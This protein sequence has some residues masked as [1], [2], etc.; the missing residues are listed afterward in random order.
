VNKVDQFESVF[1][2]AVRRGFEY[3]CIAVSKILV[4]S[5]LED[6]V[7]ARFLRRLQSFLPVLA[8]EKPRWD[9]I[10]TARFSTAEAL[11]NEVTRRAPDL[12][13]CYRNL[14]TTAWK[15]PYSLGVHLDVLL[16]CCAAPVLVVPHPKA[17]YAATH[18]L[19]ATRT[20]MA[21]VD[22]L[23]DD[24]RLVNTAVRMVATDGSLFL[25]HIEDGVVFDRY[26]DAI[27]KI[28]SIDTEQAR[29]EIAKRLLE[30][31]RNYFDSCQA[32]IAQARPDITQQRVLAFGRHLD[33]YRSSID[34]HRIDLLVMNG[35]DD[36]QMAM[37]SQAWPL[38][39]ELRQIPL[40][41]L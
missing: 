26:L 22:A 36:S 37:H 12:V 8:A 19:S 7:A 3:Q 5:D 28:A 14:A 20:V 18:A 31:S 25:T 34:E 33:A 38:A 35:K 11:L 21:V 40:L 13:C 41:I 2:A 39:I 6:D 1:R 17:G 10:S 24:D 4:V 27:G 29:E 16:Q 32:A 30:D 23:S 9:C 15:Q